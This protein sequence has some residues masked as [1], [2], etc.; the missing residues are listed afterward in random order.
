MTT[1]VPRDVVRD[2]SDEPYARLDNEITSMKTA[3]GDLSQRTTDAVGD[4]GVVAW[5]QARRGVRNARESVDS[6][7]AD[8][9]DVSAR[10]RLRRNCN[11]RRLA[12]RHRTR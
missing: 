12:T 5:K 1:D 3:I 4:F 8:A 2:A 10:L 11:L 6:A 9:A 7:V